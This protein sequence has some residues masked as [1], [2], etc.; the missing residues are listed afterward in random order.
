MWQRNQAVAK[1][2]GS[3]GMLS[4]GVRLVIFGPQFLG[5]WGCE[6][7]NNSEIHQEYTELVVSFVATKKL[8]QGDF[9]LGRHQP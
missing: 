8:Y 1:W 7:V 2:C 5:P 9:F 4:G 3:Y 6:Y